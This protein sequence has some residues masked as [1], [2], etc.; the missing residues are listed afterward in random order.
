M[1]TTKD[2]ADIVAEETNTLMAHILDRMRADNFVF[3]FTVRVE[4]RGDSAAISSLKTSLI[5]LL[6]ANESEH[7]ADLR[8]AKLMAMNTDALPLTMLLSSL[9]NDMAADL[10]KERMAEISAPVV[11]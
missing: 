1:P 6:D 2:A 11:D 9:L 4:S 10:A 8:R 3:E 7:A 5:M